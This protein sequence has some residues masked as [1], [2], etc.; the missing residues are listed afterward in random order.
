[1][2]SKV[3]VGGA[4][5]ITEL[6]TKII[7][8]N[9]L[10]IA[11]CGFNCIFSSMLCV[12][13]G[14]RGNIHKPYMR[15]LLGSQLTNCL[16]QF[17]QLVGIFTSE[18]LA[19]IVRLFGPLILI[20]AIA[21][22]DLQLLAIFSLYTDWIK[23]NII[24]NMYKA[25]LALYCI[26]VIPSAIIFI[27]AYANP[28]F[29]Y[30]ANLFYYVSAA[31]GILILLYD[32]LQAAFLTM[33]VFFKQV[34]IKSVNNALLKQLIVV[35]CF[36]VIIDWVGIVLIFAFPED[37]LNTRS[38][39][40]SSIISFHCSMLV[41]VYH[42]LRN[43][44]VHIMSKTSSVSI[45]NGIRQSVRM[46]SG[47]GQG[48]VL[49]KKSLQNSRIQAPSPQGSDAPSRPVSNAPSRPGSRAPSR[50]S[51]SKG[52]TPSSRKSSLHSFNSKRVSTT[53]FPSPIKKSRSSQLHIGPLPQTEFS[54]KKK[55][56]LKIPKPSSPDI[57]LTISPKSLY[58]PDY[59]D[60]IHDS[61]SS[62]DGPRASEIDRRISKVSQ[63]QELRMKSLGGSIQ[64]LRKEAPSKYLSTHDSIKLVRPSARSNHVELIQ[65]RR[66]VPLRP[67]AEGS[68]AH[69]HVDVIPS[70]RAKSSRRSPRREMSK[71]SSSNENSNEESSDK[72]RSSSERARAGTRTS[73]LV[74]KNNS[75]KDFQNDASSE[76]RSTSDKSKDSHPSAKANNKVK[77][78]MRIAQVDNREPVQEK[79]VNGIL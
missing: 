3:T 69:G 27:M 37:V 13:L 17:L 76:A 36:M 72:S 15:I 49:K 8:M 23:P 19:S 50:E 63:I 10:A 1:M 14:T 26:L 7:A 65:R 2:D 78:S 43:I 32:N 73:D 46:A 55:D 62:K 5:I 48:Q 21:V 29:K 25:I 16:F 12:Y 74:R 71:K 77:P 68:E 59:G 6:S 33:L 38:I 47:Q 79:Y 40:A 56:E 70:Q 22:V 66:R 44:T 54:Q 45:S 64:G 28:N 41:L 39:M 31:F 9:V 52:M 20:L 60:E 75:S 51:L 30:L 61:R 11:T 18:I 58:S 34:Q 24:K 4:C 67:L 42:Q 53:G 57:I 35:V